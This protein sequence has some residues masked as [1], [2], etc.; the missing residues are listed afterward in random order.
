MTLP[1]ATERHVAPAAA[2]QELR[3]IELRTPNVVVMAPTM[4][5]A[6][7]APV[8]MQP[9]GAYVQQPAPGYPAAPE[10]PKY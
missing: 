8:M 3:E 4:V 6:P 10:P 2:E 1:A 9:A 7:Q 5:V